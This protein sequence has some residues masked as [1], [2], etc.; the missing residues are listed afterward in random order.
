ML[1]GKIREGLLSWSSPASQAFTEAKDLLRSVSTLAHP[2]PDVPLS[3]MVDASDFAVGGVLHQHTPNTDAISPIAFFS[4]KLS[5]AQTRYSTYDHELLAIY[6]SIRHFRHIL[7][8]RHFTLFTNHKPL[9]HAL[10]SPSVNINAPA[11]QVRHLAYIL[12]NDITVLHVK[13]IITVWLI[14]YPE[15]R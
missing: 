7:E 8:G 14:P 6:L 3:L 4:K 12:E 9:V 1:R 15:G 13:V 11:R 2:M 5:P 10:T